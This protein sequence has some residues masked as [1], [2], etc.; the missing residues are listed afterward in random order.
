MVNSKHL[1]RSSMPASWPIKRKNIQFITKPNA[2]SHKLR[3]S[4]PVL[5]L[6]RD[7]LNYAKTSREVRFIVSQKDV[8]VN[9]REVD[10]VKFPV[11]MF[12]VVEIKKVNEKYIVLFDAVGKIKL[13]STKDDLV[14]LKLTK[15]TLLKGKKFQFNFANGYNIL[16]DEKAFKSTSLEDTVVYDF[17]KKKIVS[18]LPLKEGN[19]VYVFDGHFKGQFG[20][21]KKFVKYN[22]VTGDVIELEIGKASHTTSKDY[23]FVVGLKAE[24]LK[25][26]E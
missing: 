4:T 5:V 21:V 3:Y 26:F 2:G 13:V 20:L 6:L 17:A 10:D 11:G 22:G 7:V 16:V 24:D 1:K 9:G 12:D 23:C 14:Y 8:L 25:K 18:V 15:K 19:F